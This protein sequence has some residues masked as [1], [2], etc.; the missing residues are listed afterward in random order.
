MKNGSSLSVFECCWRGVSG[1]TN[2]C[3]SLCVEEKRREKKIGPDY[4]TRVRAIHVIISRSKWR[5]SVALPHLF[6]NQETRNPLEKAPYWLKITPSE[7][8]FKTCLI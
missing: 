2:R 6:T 8:E 7:I 4:N 5:R 3:F 1:L